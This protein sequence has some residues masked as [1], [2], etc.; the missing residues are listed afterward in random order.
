IRRI[1]AV[2]H[3]ITRAVTSENVVFPHQ[4]CFDQNDNLFIADTGQNRIQR[5]D[6]VTNAI[7][8]IA[9]NGNMGSSGN[10]GP[11]SAAI[12]ANPEGVAVDHTG[13]VYIADTDND[14]IRR[15][16][17]STGIIKTIAGNRHH[18]YSGDSGPATSAMLW[19]PSGVTVDSQGNL[20]IADS[21]NSRIRKV[22]AAGSI[23]TVAGKGPDSLG[24]F[25]GE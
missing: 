8:T 6:A 11:A 9:G 24:G 20:W 5:V 16:D 17:A 25:S 22:D 13:N 1:D 19:S 23:T 2:T 10:G 15:I 21:G 4:I 3:V 18:G 12:L 14:V 7:T